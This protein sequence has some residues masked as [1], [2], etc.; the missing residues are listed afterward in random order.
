M[1][2]ELQE[3]TGGGLDS[4]K[5]Y[6]P[7]GESVLQKYSSSWGGIGLIDD[8]VYYLDDNVLY[9][10]DSETGTRTQ[11]ESFDESLVSAVFSGNQIAL[12]SDGQAPYT[13]YIYTVNQS[14]SN[15][16][17]EH[18]AK[19]EAGV[20]AANSD[21]I[22]GVQ[23][24]SSDPS[25][26]TVWDWQNNQLRT[27][28]GATDTSDTSVLGIVGNTLI[29]S[30]YINTFVHAYDLTNGNFLWKQPAQ[31]NVLPSE[32]N[33]VF[34]NDVVDYQTQDRI[35]EL[36][37]HTGNVLDSWDIISPEAI[38]K[39]KDMLLVYNQDSG[40]PGLRFVDINTGEIVSS[41]LNE[42]N[43]DRSSEAPFSSSIIHNGLL[44][45]NEENNYFPFGQPAS[46][47]L[48]V[49]DLAGSSGDTHINKNYASS[50]GSPGDTVGLE[51]DWQ[52]SSSRGHVHEY[53]GTLYY[54]SDGALYE[55]DENSSS[56]TQIVTLPSESRT[57][58]HNEIVVAGG[59]G[60]EVWYNIDTD[61]KTT[62]NTDLNLV[63]S[64]ATDGNNLAFIL[65][66][67]VEVY[68]TNNNHQWSTGT[69][70][71]NRSGTI[72]NGVLVVN[73][74]ISGSKAY[75]L[76]TGN[77]LWSN[78][79][80]YGVPIESDS[81]NIFMRNQSNDTVEEIDLTGG[82]V[83]ETFDIPS[84]EAVAQ[85]GDKLFV[86]SS[87]SSQPGIRVIDKSTETVVVSGINEIHDS[88]GM[89]NPISNSIIKDGNLYINK[90]APT[91][92]LDNDLY[93][94]KLATGVSGVE[95]HDGTEWLS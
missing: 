22:V 11:I 27:F 76:S 81:S 75:N 59:T 58:G 2:K 18:D 46:N 26:F 72:V 15:D 3:L 42:L 64:I 38:Y 94:V 30:S 40:V 69:G 73:G 29:A 78:G 36:D 37:P 12:L 1:A 95:I 57:D 49:I 8:Q 14:S 65:D 80:H 13:S 61:T 87:D 93:K 9:T 92:E 6:K 35:V 41:G 4:F 10:I 20:G 86:Y 45:V 47:D 55:V 82:N 19:T 7:R 74:Y 43:Q 77:Q 85:Y 52:K 79:S 24:S 88:R 66:Q 32:N 31:G 91:S 50:S 39:Y 23:N 33:R 62:L 51:L 5:Q 56:L 63:R 67:S 44:Y 54:G 83:I 71:Y 84:G 25:E 89:K 16:L 34:F 90:N 53:N 68:N 21:Y 48:F 60:S 70:L 28:T 17:T